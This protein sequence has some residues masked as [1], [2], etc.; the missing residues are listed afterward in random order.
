MSMN[1]HI[2]AEREVLVVKTKKKDVQSIE[3]GAWQTPTDVSYKIQKA[4]DP[5]QAYKD[6]VLAQSF[7]EEEPV[8]AEDDLWGE[9]EPI[10]TETYNAGKEHITDLDCWV[11]EA[12]DEGYDIEFHVW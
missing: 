5:I 10:G 12:Q 6:W 9:R 4:A 3:F 2:I 8:Y 7:D 11:E 1:L